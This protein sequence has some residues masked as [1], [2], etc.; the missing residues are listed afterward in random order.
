MNK[1]LVIIVTPALP[2]ENN[3]NGQTSLRYKK[4]LESTYEI[5][6]CTEWQGPSGEG[7]MPS[8]MIALHARKSAASIQ[9]WAQYRQESENVTGLA[10]V[11]SGTDLYCDLP[12]DPSAQKSLRLANQLVV[13][14]E[15]AV[16]SLPLECRTKTQVI[17]QCVETELP[18]AVSQKSDRFKVIMVGHLREVKDPMTFM[19]A[20]RLLASELDVEWLHVG[21]CSDA[22]YLRGIRETE[23]VNPNYRWLDAVDHNSVL[24]FISDADLLVHCS[25]AEGSPHV[26][27]EAMALGTPVL[28]SQ[29]EGNEGTLGLG[30]SGYFPVRD[31]EALAGIVA[32]L[33]QEWRQGITD[34]LLALLGGQVIER[35]KQFSKS[36]E[37]QKINT[38]VKQLLL[39]RNIE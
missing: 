17:H 2:E 39:S 28:A 12:E 6:L 20:A 15:L 21:R 25:V 19:R 1:P 10:V 24:Q 32:T 27:I 29:V 26:V 34:Q 14:Q 8:A 30:Y 13:L 38:L 36:M 4:Y 5:H 9:A 31:H 35:S 7:P 22:D 11:L 16:N 18:I 37:S 33:A 3:G 23:A